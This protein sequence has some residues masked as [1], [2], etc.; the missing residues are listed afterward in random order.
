[1]GLRVGVGLLQERHDLGLSLLP[2]EVERGLAMLVLLGP[3]RPRRHQQPSALE[4]APL[5]GLVQAGVAGVAG[6][7]LVGA[8]L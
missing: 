2:G 8:P 7:V 1:M 3:V 5:G 4:L 6:R